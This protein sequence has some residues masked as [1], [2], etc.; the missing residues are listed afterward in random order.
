MMLCKARI[1][2]ASLSCGGFAVM[3][4]S[5]LQFPLTPSVFLGLL[6]SDFRHWHCRTSTA[7]ERGNE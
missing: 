3:G 1:V 7:M 4:S 2:L 5:Y 6:V